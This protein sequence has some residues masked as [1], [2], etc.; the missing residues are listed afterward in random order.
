MRRCLDCFA[1]RFTA[2]P[3]A[4]EICLECVHRHLI[5][6]KWLDLTAKMWGRRAMKFWEYG[7]ARKFLLKRAPCDRQEE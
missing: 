6:A 7:D 5:A 3:F 1:Y 4:T 2:R